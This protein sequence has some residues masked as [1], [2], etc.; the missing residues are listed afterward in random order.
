MKSKEKNNLLT[1]VQDK[2]PNHKFDID[3]GRLY[4]EELYCGHYNIME[5]Y[6][7]NSYG[8]TLDDVF[9]IIQFISDGYPTNEE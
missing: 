7:N 5:E 3:Q 4:C 1:L 2:F 9:E 6:I 8:M